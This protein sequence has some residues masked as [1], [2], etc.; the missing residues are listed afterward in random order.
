MPKRKATRV[1]M[2]RPIGFQ[3]SRGTSRGT[4]RDFSPRGCRI[5]LIDANIHCRMR[6]TLHV[7]LPDRAE[8]L[9]IKHAVVTW[10]RKNDFGVEFSK[11]SQ[12]TQARIQHVYDLLLDAQTPEE[13]AAISLPVLAFG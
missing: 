9:E 8:P 13:T 7:S 12:E 5:H 3:G 4:V 10:T 1:E 11:L 2:N 6:L